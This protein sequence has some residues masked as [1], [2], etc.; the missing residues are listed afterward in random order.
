MQCDRHI[1]LGADVN[2]MK[3]MYT[4]VCGDIVDSIEFI[5]DIHTDM[6]VSCA[7]EVI[8]ICGIF[9]AFEGYICYWH[10]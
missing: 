4:S 8:G 10:I 2:N 6:V 7:H 9:M 3:W 1:C 5:S